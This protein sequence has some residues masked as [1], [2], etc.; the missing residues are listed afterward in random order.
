MGDISTTT[1]ISY[2]IRRF[3][4]LLLV[5]QLVRVGSKHGSLGHPSPVENIRKA[6]LRWK[7]EKEMMAPGTSS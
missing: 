5:L 1:T 6:T 7:K 3:L 2:S 4:L